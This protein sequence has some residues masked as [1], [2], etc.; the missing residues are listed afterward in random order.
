MN[1]STLGTNG[2]NK[3][4]IVNAMDSETFQ[5]CYPAVC[6]QNSPKRIQPSKSHQKGFLSCRLIL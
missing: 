2:P 3:D 1:F 4:M 6:I 5:Q